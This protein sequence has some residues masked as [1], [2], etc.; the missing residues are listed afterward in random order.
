M[1]T[2]HTTIHSWALNNAVMFARE[3]K[4]QNLHNALGGIDSL[5]H[6]KVGGHVLDRLV[7]DLGIHVVISHILG[8]VGD[9][10][11]TITYNQTD[12]QLIDYDLPLSLMSTG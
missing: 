8:L 1:P 12:A 7:C 2:T 5:V 11:R 3:A 9:V 6:M 10:V 4:K